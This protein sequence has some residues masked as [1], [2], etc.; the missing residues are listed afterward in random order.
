MNNRAHMLGTKYGDDTHLL[1]NYPAQAMADKNNGSIG[2]R[3]LELRSAKSL[4]STVAN[5][6]VSS[7]IGG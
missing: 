2:D 7:P 3:I 6:L 1:H 4:S 5:I